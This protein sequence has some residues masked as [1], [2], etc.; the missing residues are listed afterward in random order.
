MERTAKVWGE[1]WLLRQDSTHAVSY[2]RLK[3]NTRCSWHFH[4]S[5]WNLFVVLRGKVG[6]KTE[7]GEIVLTEG[8]EFTVAPMLWHEFRVYENSD[9]IE[10]MYIQYDESDIERKDLGSVL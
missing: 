9:M 1:R 3:K 4:V 7:H 2:L 8:Q 5:K 6:I 10:E